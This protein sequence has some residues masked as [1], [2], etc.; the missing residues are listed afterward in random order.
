[1]VGFPGRLP[2]IAG[3]PGRVRMRILNAARTAGLG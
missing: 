2:F 1:V 3:S